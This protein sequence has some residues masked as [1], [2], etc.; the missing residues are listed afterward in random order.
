MYVWYL[1]DADGIGMEQ[2]ESVD[3][4][5]AWLQKKSHFETPPEGRV[6]VLMG[7]KE[8]QHCRFR[9]GFSEEDIVFHTDRYTVYGYESYE[10]MK[11][12][13]G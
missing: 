10:D 13:L 9:R 8:M 6:F 4:L 7:K 11:E 2:T 12:A 5:Y 1:T 3:D